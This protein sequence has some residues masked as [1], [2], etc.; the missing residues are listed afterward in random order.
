MR[1]K[2]WAPGDSA[3]SLGVFG[4]YHTP[5]PKNGLGDYHTMGRLSLLS[6]D[7]IVAIGPGGS[8]DNGK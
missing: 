7:E 4:G 1:T 8:D 6:D 2:E 3:A 5:K